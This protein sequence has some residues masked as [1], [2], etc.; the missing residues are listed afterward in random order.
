MDGGSVRHR[1]RGKEMSLNGTWTFGTT[2]AK[3]PIRT[4]CCSMFW[5]SVAAFNNSKLPKIVIESREWKG[6]HCVYSLKW[7]RM[8]IWSVTLLFKGMWQLL[9]DVQGAFVCSSG[10][11]WL[12]RR[13]ELPMGN[14]EFSPTLSILDR[15]SLSYLS[16]Q[17]LKHRDV[18]QWT[19]QCPLCPQ[20]LLYLTDEK[21][22]FQL[23]CSSFFSS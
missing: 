12:R 6:I 23:L 15:P 19:S 18:V 17:L 16:N 7:V 5:G 11:S 2:W 3:S 22:V 4:C 14:T 8:L 13:M 9:L 1:G 20:L 10:V 21:M